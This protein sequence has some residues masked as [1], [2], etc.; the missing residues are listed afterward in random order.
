MDLCEMYFYMVFINYIKE[1]INYINFK[2][3]RFFLVVW[4][5]FRSISEKQGKQY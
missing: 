5:I 2:E 1:Y 3:Y 4:Q